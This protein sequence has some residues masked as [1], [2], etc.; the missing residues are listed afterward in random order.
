MRSRARVRLR[1]KNGV[2]LEDTVA[3]GPVLFIAAR[4]VKAPASADILDSTGLLQPPGVHLN[5]ALK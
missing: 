3:D 5:M 1:F 2:E 4:V